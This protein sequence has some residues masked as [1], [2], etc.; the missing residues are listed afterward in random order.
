M[1]MANAADPVCERGCEA[2]QSA[3]GSEARNEWR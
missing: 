3:V 2:R 1:Q